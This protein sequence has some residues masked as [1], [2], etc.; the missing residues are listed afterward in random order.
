MPPSRP[1]HRRQSNCEGI[2]M[3]KRMSVCGTVLMA[4][5]CSNTTT[6]ATPT[7]P[8]PSPFAGLVG[9]YA[10]TVEIDPACTVVTSSERV[11]R[12][13]AVIEDGPRAPS[14]APITVRGGGFTDPTLLGEL[15]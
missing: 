8:A 9:N 2:A 11:R 14:L 13:D 7:T 4:V 12:Y 5:A 10:L 15:W 6:P 1:S 3:L